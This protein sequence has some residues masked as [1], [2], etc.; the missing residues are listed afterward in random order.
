MYEEQMKNKY[1]IVGIID[2]LLSINFSGCIANDNKNREEAIPDDV[3][4]MKKR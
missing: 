2:V 3:V 4:K 1:I